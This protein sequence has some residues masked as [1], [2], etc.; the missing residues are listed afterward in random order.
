MTTL[1]LYLA[2]A[3]LVS[4]LCSLLEASLLS[5]PATH[6]E[7]LVRSGRRSGEILRDLKAR[8]DRPLAAI[9]TLNTIANTVGAAGV[10]AQALRLFG[11]KWVAVA[12]GTL[13]LMILVF[14]EIIPKTLGATYCQGL[15]SFTAYATRA[16]IWLT[17]PAVVLSEKISRFI[18]RGG[19]VPITREEMI[20]TAEMGETSGALAD[21]ERHIITNLVRL[22]NV[23]VEDVMTPR[24]VVL[25][26]QRDL[27]VAEAVRKDHPLPFSRIPVYGKDQDDIIG[28]VH[29][30]QILEAYSHG[31]ADR[32][33]G[34]LALPLYRILRSRTVSSA[35]EE[36]IA[37]Q[38]HVFL[39]VDE[40]GGT[41]GIITLEDAVETLL[42]V[43]IVDE[44]DSVED[45]R[46]LARAQWERRKREHPL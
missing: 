26:M 9:L 24:A 13:T 10:G 21:R 12:S 11:S 18:S 37:R 40:F 42:G 15:A 43:E 44:Y 34:S 27:T 25:A 22:E 2:L 32:E 39:V 7:V 36:F 41:A 3:V 30:Y 45:M 4:F 46:K 5:V 33:L 1:F 35:L 17:Y 38:D 8:L 29:R 28:F 6:V 23:L 20:V 14:S 31:E 19:P 16:L